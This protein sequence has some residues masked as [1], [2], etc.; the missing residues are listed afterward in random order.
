MLLHTIK[1]LL[2]SSSPAYEQSKLRYI[3]QAKGRKEEVTLGLPTT[4]RLTSHLR[5]KV[6][7]TGRKLS[8]QPQAQCKR[9]KEAWT[10]DAATVSPIQG[11]V[12]IVLPTRKPSDTL[13][14]IVSRLNTF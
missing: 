12:T 7:G 11:R 3:Q 1:L 6:G 9:R 8:I 10:L 13:G 4:P 5:K 14:G 2:A